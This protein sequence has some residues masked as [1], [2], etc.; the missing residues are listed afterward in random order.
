MSAKPHRRGHYAWKAAPE[1]PGVGGRAVCVQEGRSSGSRG[2]RQPAR[3]GSSE[4][5]I[6]QR[7]PRDNICALLQ[8]RITSTFFLA[9]VPWS[10][11]EG[12]VTGG[13]DN[14]TAR[15][16]AVRQGETL[17]VPALTATF[18]QIIAINRAGGWRKLKCG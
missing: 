17:N 11:R 1:P 12:I 6:E 18:K 15:T 13:H 5:Q 8:P 4:R 7:L 16:V 9:T 2:I 10:R 3:V 14:Q